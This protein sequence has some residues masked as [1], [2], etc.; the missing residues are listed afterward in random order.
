MNESDRLIAERPTCASCK[1]E[2]DPDTCW[3]GSERDWHDGSH[4]YVPMGCTCYYD[5][6]AVLAAT[7]GKGTMNTFYV[8]QN[9]YVVTL[10]GARAEFRLFLDPVEARNFFLDNEHT[11]MFSFSVYQTQDGGIDRSNMTRMEALAAAIKGEQG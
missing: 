6:A 1:N 3:C 11:D 5:R 2:I 7:E 9:V 4:H 8:M 10:P